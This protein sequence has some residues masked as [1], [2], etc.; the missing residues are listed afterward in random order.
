MIVMLFEYRI[1][2]AHL[3]DYV[4]QVNILRK[5]V[6]DIDG[7]ISIERFQSASDPT[8]LLGI[9]Y[10]KD[11]AAVEQW[12]KLPQHRE[13]QALGRSTLFEDYRLC[14]AEVIRDY[15]LSDRKQVPDD[16]LKYHEQSTHQ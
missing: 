4:N 9:G 7:F 2:E 11:E 6:K 15:S 10:F 14:M 12:R 5:L 13:A 16:S 3:E 1:R 8:R